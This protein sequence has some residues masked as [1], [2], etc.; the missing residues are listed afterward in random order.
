MQGFERFSKKYC[1]WWELPASHYAHNFNSNSN[2]TS[3]SL[4]EK[5]YVT[6]LV[7]DWEV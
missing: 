2:S 4:T 5:N 7:G 3:I 1:K 6:L